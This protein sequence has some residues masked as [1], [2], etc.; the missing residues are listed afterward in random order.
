MNYVL[1]EKCKYFEIHTKTCVMFF[2]VEEIAITPTLVT[3]H[4]FFHL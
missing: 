3:S 2:K 1:H 4:V